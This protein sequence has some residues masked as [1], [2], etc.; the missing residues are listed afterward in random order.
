MSKRNS[1]FQRLTIDTPKDK[2]SFIWPI[3]LIIALIT[4]TYFLGPDNYS[5]WLAQ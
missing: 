5:F 3:S 1:Q 4:L 2:L